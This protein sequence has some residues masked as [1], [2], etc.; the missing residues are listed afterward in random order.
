MIHTIGLG[1]PNILFVA[2]KPIAADLETLRAAPS[3]AYSLMMIGAG[4]AAF[5]AGALIE[6]IRRFGRNEPGAAMGVVLPRCS[7]PGCCCLNNPTHRVC[8][9]MSS[10]R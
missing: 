2:L 1:A 8:I 4:A 10:T 7:L 3:F 5:V 9:S 6:A